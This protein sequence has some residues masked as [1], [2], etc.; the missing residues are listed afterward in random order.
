MVTTAR[1]GPPI[2]DRGKSN[3][4]AGLSIA[5]QFVPLPIMAELRKVSVNV[6]TEQIYLIILEAISWL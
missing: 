1:T 5:G 4:G 2:L 6:P 3:E